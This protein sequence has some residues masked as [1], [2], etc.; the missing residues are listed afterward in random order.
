MS[1][2]QFA[3]VAEDERDQEPVAVE[4]FSDALRP[5]LPARHRRVPKPRAPRSRTYP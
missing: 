3:T 4:L 2:A 5:D 1:R